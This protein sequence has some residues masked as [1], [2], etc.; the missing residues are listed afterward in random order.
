MRLGAEVG[1]HTGQDDLV[2]TALA[3]LQHQVVGFRAIDLVRTG[4]DRLAIL[5]VGLVLL[6]PIGAGTREAIDIQCAFTI[7]HA[8]SVH[9]LF[10]RTLK[11]PA[12]VV[13]VVIMR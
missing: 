4:D 11:L 1:G 12:V 8:D 6:Q 5:D 10:E 3:Q 7:E 9:Q 2:D 13:G